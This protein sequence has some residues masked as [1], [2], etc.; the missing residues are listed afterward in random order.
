MTTVQIGT[1]TSRVHRR[2]DLVV[3]ETLGSRGYTYKIQPFA[4]ELIHR[5]G[6]QPDFVSVIGWRLTGGVPMSTEAAITFWIGDP[7]HT[8]AQIYGGA[9]QWLLAAVQ[10]AMA[11]Q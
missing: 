2:V 10:K 7:Q 6:A 9:P 8:M 4:I 5:L 1:F 11:E 3:D